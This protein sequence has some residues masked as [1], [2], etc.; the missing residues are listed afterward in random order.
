M[1][2]W[3][4]RAGKNGEQEH[5]ALENNVC[6]IGWNELPDLSKITNKE[7]LTKIY[8]QH[9]EDETERAAIIRI[10]QIWRFVK[11]IKIEDMI[12]LPLKSERSV[13]I[14]KINE[15]YTYKK[16]SPIIQHTRSVQW[17]GKIPR[18]SLLEHKD[19][20]YSLGAHLTVAR[21]WANDAENR[22]KKILDNESVDSGDVKDTTTDTSRLDHEVLSREDIIDTIDRNFKGHDFE[23]LVDSILRAKGFTT[24][25]AAEGPDHGID[26]FANRG[27]GDMSICVQ[28]KSSKDPVQEHVVRDLRG[29]CKKHNAKCGLLVAWGGINKSA[30]K[31]IMCPFF[32]MEVWDHNRILN[33]IFKNYEKLDDEIRKKLPLKQIMVLSDDE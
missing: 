5:D 20:L 10:N 33:E 11:D 23:Y 30:K 12:A 28:V 7:E 15:E 26:I 14:G 19:I 29:A 21:M 9:Y 22:I 17:M 16:I 13:A 2:L 32:E 8:H 3:L 24:N 18:S 31:E 25:V 4:I 6:V 27:F 1:T